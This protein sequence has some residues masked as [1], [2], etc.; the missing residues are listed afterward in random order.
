MTGCTKLKTPLWPCRLDRDQQGTRRLHC[1]TPGSGA[2][3]VAQLRMPRLCL[4]PQAGLILRVHA[5]S[6]LRLIDILI[7]EVGDGRSGFSAALSGFS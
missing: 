6:T 3:F 1:P 4:R 2:K 7:R 5:L